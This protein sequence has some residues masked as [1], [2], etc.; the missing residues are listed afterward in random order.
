MLI[1]T[2]KPWSEQG[3]G[4]PWALSNAPNRCMQVFSTNE[5]ARQLYSQLGYEVKKLNTSKKLG[6]KPIK[7]NKLD[8]SRKSYGVQSP[9]CTG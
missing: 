3:I 9:V 5:R 8:I 6:F 7:W 2:P 1:V 4:H